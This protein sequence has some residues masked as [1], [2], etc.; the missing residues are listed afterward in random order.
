MINKVRAWEAKRLRLTFRP[1]MMPDD[2]KIS[3]KNL[4]EDGSPLSTEK[5]ASK[6]WTTTDVGRLRWGCSQL[7]WLFVPFLGGELPLGGEACLLGYGEG[8]LQRTKVEAQSCVP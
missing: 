6:I 4:E 1:R 3:T 5:I 8:P 2:I 7:C